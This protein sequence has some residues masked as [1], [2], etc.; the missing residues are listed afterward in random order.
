ML[1]AFRTTTEELKNRSW[2][3]QIWGYFS[4]LCLSLQQNGESYSLYSH[5][6]SMSNIN[7]LLYCP[8][9]GNWVAGISEGK[10]V[11]FRDADSSLKPQMGTRIHI[12]FTVF[13]RKI[14]WSN[15]SNC[16]NASGLTLL[17]AILIV[18]DFSQECKA[19]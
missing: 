8:P 3:D 12:L 5:H 4:L 9:N 13:S 14:E 10:S 16:M 1:H 17:R 18:K 7:L 19:Q 11:I 6:E 2:N 15:L